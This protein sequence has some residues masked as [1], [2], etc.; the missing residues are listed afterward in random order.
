MDLR[1]YKKNVDQVQTCYGAIHLA[2][3]CN[4]QP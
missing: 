1:K 3:N 4:A 2:I